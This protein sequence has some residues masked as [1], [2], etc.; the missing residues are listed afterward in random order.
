MAVWFNP[1]FAVCLVLFAV[2]LQ[3]SGVACVR[4][5]NIRS[6]VLLM[7][8][9]NIY[10]L[11]SLTSIAPHIVTTITSIGVILPI[12]LSSDEVTVSSVAGAPLVIAGTVMIVSTRENNVL[13]T[14]DDAVK[15]IMSLITAVFVVAGVVNAVS[16]HVHCNPDFEPLARRYNL[17][18]WGLPTNR[19]YAQAI[20]VLSAAVAAVATL[21]AA[22]MFSHHPSVLRFVGMAIMASSDLFIATSSLLIN[23]VAFHTPVVFGLWAIAGYLILDPLDTRRCYAFDSINSTGLALTLLGIVTAT[24]NT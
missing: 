5:R 19:L 18:R 20:A 8:A 22:E 23:K 14:Y 3:S 12:L 6:G 24:R 13:C 10:I 15:T 2:V 7:V 1:V 9:G 11:W 16:I 21:H 17:H 4:K